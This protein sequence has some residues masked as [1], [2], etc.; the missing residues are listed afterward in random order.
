M[1]SKLLGAYKH[2]WANRQ[3]VERSA[4]CGCFHCLGIFSAA[5]V[6]RWTHNRTTA[7]CPLCG[8]DAVIGDASGFVIEAGMLDQL[9]QM[10]F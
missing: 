10:W 3:E 5:E 2:S 7:L 8:V 6:Q 9:K 4:T 1:D